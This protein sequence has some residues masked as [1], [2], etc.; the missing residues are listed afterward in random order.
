M[1]V[2][3]ITS[4]FMFLVLSSFLSIA[5]EGTLKWKCA[6]GAS[7]YNPLAIGVGGNIYG[8][9]QSAHLF[10]I[11]SS[12]TTQWNYQEGFFSA[13][14]IALDGTIYVG[15][16]TTFQAYNPNG[17]LEWSTSVYHNPYVYVVTAALGSDST[18]YIGSSYDTTLRA[19]TPQ[20]TQIWK[21][22][23]LEDTDGIS[24]NRWSG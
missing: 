17:T 19:L 5:Q 6:T 7:I 4:L 12:G 10:S 14:V 1:K 21:I 13:P 20:G 11:Y 9:N 24:V 2:F 22:N 8:V 15:N 3:R 23:L 16:A 18:I